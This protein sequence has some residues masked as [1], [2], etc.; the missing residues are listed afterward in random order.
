MLVRVVQGFI[1]YNLDIM[2]YESAG[3][4]CIVTTIVGMICVH[5]CSRY[6]DIRLDMLHKKLLF[7]AI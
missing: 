7:D 2:E 5:V 1:G 4:V 6:M 3:I